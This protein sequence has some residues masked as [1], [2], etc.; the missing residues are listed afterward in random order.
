M[1]AEAT[2]TDHDGRAARD[3]ALALLAEPGDAQAEPR[4][5]LE[6][7]T[8]RTVHR[9]LVRVLTGAGRADLLSSGPVLSVDRVARQGRAMMHPAD[10]AAVHAVLAAH[11]DDKTCLHLFGARLLHDSKQR[12]RAARAAVAPAAVP[13]VG[14]AA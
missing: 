5:V 14:A 7:H 13:S 6:Q 1:T 11:G 8:A 4:F 10:M 9:A 3:A 2:T 12:W